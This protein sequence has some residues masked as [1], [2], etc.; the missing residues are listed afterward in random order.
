MADETE[1][2]PAPETPVEAPV[3]TPTTAPEAPAEAPEA[4]EAPAVAPEEETEPENEPD[5]AEAD[6]P[7]SSG[8]YVA[9]TAM[10]QSN[11]QVVVDRALVM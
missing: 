8:R 3:E 10:N 9:S 7:V 1:I 5:A 4:P 2:N 11:G 6:A